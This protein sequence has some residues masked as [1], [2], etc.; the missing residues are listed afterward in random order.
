MFPFIFIIQCFILCIMA[1]ASAPD[2]ESLVSMVAF[3]DVHSVLV[4]SQQCEATFTVPP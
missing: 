4:L 2:M 1:I 3:H